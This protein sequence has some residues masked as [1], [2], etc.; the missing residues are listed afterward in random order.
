MCQSK[1]D[2]MHKQSIKKSTRHNTYQPLNDGSIQWGKGK[3]IATIEWNWDTGGCKIPKH[4]QRIQ[5]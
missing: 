3:I 5:S 4:C 2:I 1:K